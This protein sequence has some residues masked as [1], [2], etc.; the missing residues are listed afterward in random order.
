[1]NTSIRLLLLVA[2]VAVSAAL[3]LLFDG[4]NTNGP[5]QS[6]FILTSWGVIVYVSLSFAGWP[7]LFITFVTYMLILFLLNNYLRHK[8]QSRLPLV[9][10]LIHGTGAFICLLFAVRDEVQV[11]VI[12]NFFAWIIPLVVA[13]SY[14]YFDWQLARKG[15]NF[16]PASCNRK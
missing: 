11:G 14:F 16:E 13:F 2:Y 5:M 8:A 9:P 1:M 6:L 3:I 10:F 12:T 4:F 15:R 7:L